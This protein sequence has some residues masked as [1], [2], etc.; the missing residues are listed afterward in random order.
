MKFLLIILLFCI[1]YK[2]PAQKNISGLY[3]SACDS[4]YLYPD[5][6]FIFKT[7]DRFITYNPIIKHITGNWKYVNDTIEFNNCLTIANTTGSPFA[8]K[9]TF[10]ND[11][12]SITVLKLYAIFYKQKSF[13]SDCS[14]KTI[15]QYKNYMLH[16]DV[17]TYYKN[18]TI[19]DIRKFRK[20]KKVGI[21]KFYNMNS[22]LIMSEK[23]R[24]DK[25]I[26]TEIQKIK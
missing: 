25:N 26:Y 16:G 23:Y 14:I 24:N 1:A 3:T 15:F 22:K 20:G 17:I 21:W 18:G 19:A 6:T 2:Y 9:F 5:S 10:Y 7:R 12:L 4:I 11:T 13:H 8:N